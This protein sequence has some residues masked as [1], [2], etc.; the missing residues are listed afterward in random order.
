[1]FV[2]NVDPFH[3]QKLNNLVQSLDTIRQFCSTRLHHS[4]SVFKDGKE[5]HKTEFLGL[6]YHIAMISIGNHPDMVLFG[7]IDQI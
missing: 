3:R 5:M 7:E 1:M 4:N 6:L 2:A